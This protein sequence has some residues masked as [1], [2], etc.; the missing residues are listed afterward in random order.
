MAER[1]TELR[2]DI[3]ETRERMTG[4][5]DAIG[6]RVSPGRVVE[7]RVNRFRQTSSRVRMSTCSSSVRRNSPESRRCHSQVSPGSASSTSCW[8]R[9]KPTAPDWVLL[10]PSGP[11]TKEGVERAF[12]RVVDSYWERLF[13]WLRLPPA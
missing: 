11:N 10:L 6:D 12:A 3:E 5:M 2:R 8:N 1:T 13:R 9:S 7:R 4:T